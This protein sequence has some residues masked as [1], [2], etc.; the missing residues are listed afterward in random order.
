MN[1]LLNLSPQEGLHR[2]CHQRQADD[3]LHAPEQT[4]LPVQTVALC[5][6]ALFRVHGARHDCSQHCGP[7]DEGKAPPYSRGESWNSLTLKDC[8]TFACYSASNCE[9]QLTMKINLQR[10]AWHKSS[11]IKKLIIISS[12]NSALFFI[13]WALTIIHSLQTDIFQPL[14]YLL[15]LC[16]LI[17]FSVQWGIMSS[18]L[19]TLAWVLSPKKGV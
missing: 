9:L 12:R 16:T 19:G 10:L 18:I 15:M 2:L 4:N 7:H 11:T 8:T 17:V 6:I 14:P 3:P 5:G 13:F 1:V